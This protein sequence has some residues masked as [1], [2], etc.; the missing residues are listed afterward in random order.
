MITDLNLLKAG[1]TESAFINC[2]CMEGMKRF[3]DKWFDL[4]VVDPPYGDAMNNSGGVEPIRSEIRQVQGA[5]HVRDP[6]GQSRLREEAAH[7]RGNTQK[8]LL[9]GM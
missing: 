5:L 7:G 1:I 8:K 3:P 4:A 2:D 9:R 6:K